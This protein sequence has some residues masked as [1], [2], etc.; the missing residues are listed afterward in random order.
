MP[1]ADSEMHHGAVLE[2]KT[3]TSTCRI[4]H[5]CAF[6]LSVLWSRADVVVLSRDHYYILMGIIFNL[7]RPILAWG[8]NLASS[9]MQTSWKLRQ[10]AHSRENFERVW[11]CTLLGCKKGASEVPAIIKAY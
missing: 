2:Y 11:G 5:L 8:E 1:F 3:T 7:L 6:S 10:N 9:Q 4:W